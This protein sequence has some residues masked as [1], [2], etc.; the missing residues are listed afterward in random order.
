M[1]AVG[2]LTDVNIENF[3]SVI[4]DVLRVN[5]ILEERSLVESTIFRSREFL[6]K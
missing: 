2:F 6:V 1:G 3:E 4:N 5:Y